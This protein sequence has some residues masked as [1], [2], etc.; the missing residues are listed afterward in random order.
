MLKNNPLNLFKKNL[1]SE[2]RLNS[3]IL[4][5]SIVFIFFLSFYFSLFIF[6]KDILNINYEILKDFFKI[7]FPTFVL[8]LSLVLFIF[9]KN[10][11]KNLLK[12][13][14]IIIAFL[15]NL[16]KGNFNYKINNN[17]NEDFNIIKDSLNDLQFKL[18]RE[19]NQRKK[20]E[21]HRRN[22]ILN[23]SHDLKT[24]FTNILGYI[25]IIKYHDEIDQ[26]TKN[27]YIDIII[28]NIN[29]SNK[30]LLDLNDLTKMQSKD[31][32]Y[33]F[34]RYDIN[35][36]LREIIIEYIPKFET[37]NIDY[38][39]LITNNTVHSMI[40]QKN[41]SKAIYNILENVIK[42]SKCSNINIQL[43]LQNEKNYQIIITDDGIGIDESYSNEIFEPFTK[44][45]FSRNS[46]IDGSGLGLSI[47]NSIINRHG[48]LLYLDKTH[49][50]GSKF[51]I[52]MPILNYN[53]PILKKL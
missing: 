3:I 19:I 9:F 6:K 45:D 36:T 31:Y 7:L 12:P 22:F 23:I 40:D 17:F 46:K 27:K 34:Q 20:A 32:L 37:N 14:K 8:L 21:E 48:G 43:D 2:L 49:N 11:S 18:E 29:R 38:N 4:F 47:S 1:N 26:D 44:A 53:D 41:F 35:E 15:E 51:V 50:K 24:P 13:I 42:H 16:K 30:L 5:L 52:D 10:I 28:S 39:V 33:I 25:E